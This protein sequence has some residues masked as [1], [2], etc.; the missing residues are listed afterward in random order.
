MRD[1]YKK[2]K[3]DNTPKKEYQEWTDADE[4]ELTKAMSDHAELSDT[5]LAVKKNNRCRCCLL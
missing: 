2:L 5:A 1:W 3:D 4:D